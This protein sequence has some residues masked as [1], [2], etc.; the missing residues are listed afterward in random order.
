VMLTIYQVSV[1]VIVIVKL[2][3]EM[4]VIDWLT[5]RVKVAETTSLGLIL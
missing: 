4:P 3:L 5:V 2:K 1:A